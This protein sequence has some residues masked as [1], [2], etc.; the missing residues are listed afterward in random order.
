MNKFKKDDKVIVLKGK[1][2]GKKGI[3]L[4]V[5]PNSSKVII[6]KLNIS[7]KH[8]KSQQDKKGGILDVPQPISWSNIAL[9]DNSNNVVSRVNYSINKNTKIRLNNKTNKPL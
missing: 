4:K 8:V 6:D 9:I 2:K 1:D 7:K 3:I 5:L